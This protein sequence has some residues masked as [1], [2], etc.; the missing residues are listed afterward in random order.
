MG[1]WSRWRERLAGGRGR[2]TSE[3][4]AGGTA[5][6]ER[7]IPSVPPE[8]AYLRQL[9]GR[10]EAAAGGAAQAPVSLGRP[11]FW[12]AI[13]R[14]VAEGRERKASEFLRRFAALR[15]E[16]HD[17]T[18]RLAELLCES[19]DHTAA[20]PLLGRLVNA[21]E[22]RSYAARA[23]FLLGEIYEHGGQLDLAR[24]HYE[25]VLGLDIDYPNVRLRAERVR[26]R[27]VEPPPGPGGAAPTLLGV[28][29]ALPG[30]GDRY[31]LLR[32]LGRGTAGAVYLA[33]DL[34]LG[35][36]V[37][38][39][40][41]HPRAAARERKEVRARSFNEA[42]IAAALRHPGVVAIY[43]IDE[44][45]NLIAMELCAG[46][47]LRDR[48]QRGRLTPR[49]AL[50]RGM[51][52]CGTLAAVHRAGI[53]H[54]DLKP[55][56]LLFRAPLVLPASGGSAGAVAPVVQEG[57]GW[58]PGDGELVLADFG[59][60]HLEDERGQRE[61]RRDAGG[62]TL[63]YMAPERRRGEASAAVDLYAVGVILY[64]MLA[65]AVRADRTALLRGE[66]PLA[67]LAGNGGEG[68]L[69][70]AVARQLGPAAGAVRAL[71][72]ALVAPEPAARPSAAAARE[73]LAEIMGG[74]APTS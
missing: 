64:E 63:L 25:A 18:A 34:E 68:L 62:G 52:L 32:E 4:A 58:L 1:L 9:L 40:L 26:P 60:A 57:L 20:L 54:L 16:Q 11:E 31:R 74:G 72:A 67:P 37:A 48:L 65:G 73:R 6:G 36:E 27:Q 17:I 55:G 12:A 3:A 28:E 2:G 59:L 38:L 24:D 15:P 49:E 21:P 61:G 66:H 13:D 29:G 7:T 71:L 10:L 44:E 46:G 45:A 56:N 53:V 50:G 51:E 33:Q 42:R 41:L 43:D 35:R 5:E 23:H 39:K 22:A 47:T 19:L 70:A 69:P 8:E 30:L 14:L